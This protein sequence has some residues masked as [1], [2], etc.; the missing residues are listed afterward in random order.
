MAGHVIRSIRQTGLGRGR[1]SDQAGYAPADR[2]GFK[3]K[4]LRTFATMVTTTTRS[5]LLTPTSGKRVRL[6]RV[7]V[8]QETAEAA[9]LVEI[10]FGTGTNAAT[11]A[12]KVIQILNVPNGG[13][14]STRTFDKLG[15]G[16]VGLVNE[17]VSYRWRA[18]PANAHLI[19]IE[20][21][22]E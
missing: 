4:P 16:P 22:E 5:T 13:E 21:L 2:P 7:T 10:Y 20:Y 3:D 1:G 6:I 9:Q 12:S 8:R 14:V 15:D 18:A 19:L 17:V 11:T